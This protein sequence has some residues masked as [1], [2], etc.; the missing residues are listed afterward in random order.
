MSPGANE[1]A[2]GMGAV[3]YKVAG[4]GPL[5]TP[6]MAVAGAEV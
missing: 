4:V 2:T 3:M 6:V 5:G 1:T